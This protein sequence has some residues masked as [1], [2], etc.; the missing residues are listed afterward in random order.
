MYRPAPLRKFVLIDGD[1]SLGNLGLGSMSVFSTALLLVGFG[2]LHAISA[3]IGDLD[4]QLARA[5]T[6]LALAAA[7]L[8]GAIFLV[9]WPLSESPFIY[10]QF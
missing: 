1:L 4:A 8:A 10:F 3:R 7:F 6:A 2:L 5:P 9:L